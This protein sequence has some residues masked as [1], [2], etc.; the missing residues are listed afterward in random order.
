MKA[1]KGFILATTLAIITILT[2]AGVIGT[3][4]VTKETRLTVDTSD[5][6]KALKAAESG[7]EIALA[8]LKKGEIPSSPLNGTINGA[9]YEVTVSEVSS[10]YS[11]VSVGEKDEAERTIKVFVQKVG[12]SFYPFAINGELKI[13]DFNDLG[14]GGWTEAIV[15]VKEIPNELREALEN[16]NFTVN[17]RSI[18]INLP[19]VADLDTSN[20]YPPESECD[21]GNYNANATYS[22]LHFEDQN[23]DGKIV[24][25]GKNITLDRTLIRFN[26]DLTVAATGSIYFTPNTTLKKD[27]GSTSNLSLIAG[28]EMVFD[29]NSNIDFAGADAGFNILIYAK[30][31]IVSEDTTGQWISISGNQN[32][33]NT[34]NLLILTPGE[35]KVNR[36]LVD[37]T[38]V[39]R[40]DVN[41]LI[42]ADK[43][44]YSSNG[45]FDISGHSET[46]RNFA[47][48]VPDGNATFDRWQ[49]TGS[50][51]RSGLTYE[52]II[53]YCDDDT[54]PDFY[55]NIF[56]QLKDQ[57]GGSSSR[58]RMQIKSWRIY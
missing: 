28:G 49:F 46:V 16:A 45:G 43:G 6:I 9:T 29:R 24:V 55:R 4:I 30:E 1:R 48:I 8:K 36:D 33:E 21:Y 34:S 31:G 44:I 27:T 13:N 18:D 25:C 7:V 15:T 19:K 41:F 10:G 23:G 14:S 47:V 11:I 2:V 58:S 3:Y 42:W 39:T 53:N 26:D 56:C 22:E 12:T 50:E 57:I 40:K 5:S 32:T 17:I 52:D 20:F 37:D 35:I 54:I 51:D 38:A